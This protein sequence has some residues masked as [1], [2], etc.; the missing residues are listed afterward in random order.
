[1]RR[2]LLTLALLLLLTSSA[3]LAGSAR[4]GLPAGF[5]KQAIGSGWFE[6]VGV[7][8]DDN[9]RMYVWERVGKVWIVENG[10]KLSPPL[11][12]ISDEVGSWRDHGMLGFA[13][14]PNFLSNGW[15]YLFYAVDHYHLQNAGTPGY[16]PNV[17]ES[18]KPSIGRITRYTATAASGFKATDPASRRVLLGESAST[19]CP[20]VHDSHGVG[21][22]VFGSDDSL[23][24]GCGDGGSFLG[25]DVGG[26]AFGSYTVQALAEGIIAPRE[27]V[28]A[29][30]AQLV[31]S[32]AG[33]LLRIDAQTGDGLPSNPYYDP[34]DPRSARSRVFALGLRNPFRFTVRPDTG[35]HFQ[36]DG[37][38]GVIYLGNVGWRFFEE[39]DVI[40]SAA[41]NGG[42]PVYEAMTFEPGY[43]VE[44]APPNLDA[45][46]PLA[47]VNGCPQYFSF[48]DLLVQETL[49]APSFPNPCAPAQQIPASLPRHMHRRPAIAY[50]HSAIGPMYV[51][52]FTAG[53]PTTAEV[54]APGSPTAG[55]PIGG[56]TATGD[57][58]YTGKDFPAEFQSSYFHSDLAGFIV[59]VRFDANDKPT[60]VTPFETESTSAVVMLATDPK[61]GGLYAV[62]ILGSVF[63]ISYNVGANLPPVAVASASPG[64]GA[65][66]VGVAFTGSASTDPEGL[67]LTH[68][69]NF[70]DGSPLA[71][72]A[73]PSHT[74]FGPVGVPTTYTITLTVTD[75][76]GQPSVALTQVVVN[77][78]PPAVAITSPP[79]QGLFSMLTS[80]VYPLT[81]N[82]SDLE[83]GAGQLVCQWQMNLHHNAHAHPL[84]ETAACTSSATVTP[85]GCEGSFDYY[86]FRLTV[87]DGRG[88]ST[89]REVS[90][91]PDCAPLF[92]V[93]CGNIDANSVRNMVD[94]LRLRNAF[95]NPLTAGLST[96]E[97][98]RC[99][100][101][102]DTTCDLV[103]LTVL[104]RYLVSRAPGIYP[105]CTAA[106]P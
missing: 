43:E 106:S 37:D 98:A 101:I 32:L 55:T 83:Q 104:R 44:I 40:D 28:G 90:I 34:L 58:W 89:A 39:I 12:D 20:L 27:D 21:A 99:S 95:A 91:Y 5:T 71:T 85:I 54:G 10:V 70:G 52:T 81:A 59:N 49:A 92:P 18:L 47:G 53:A 67:P 64:F 36:A 76:L 19:G 80:T 74:F 102:G 3:W 42:W 72:Q 77:N 8:F 78:T 97:R 45:P 105:V 68:S 30:R 13:L 61:T 1:M 29:Y 63:R 6:P 60:L 31:S 7:A 26:P 69:W 25:A 93:I 23:L 2:R 65:T 57:V 103:D 14:H 22:L 66:P 51:P 48:R 87:D 41:Y 11:I 100:V 46:N 73:N 75:S 86:S 56:F 16:D 4:A 82:V 50:G 96:G 9:G 84:A 33:K 88:L 79:N 15:F 35:S 17:S 62:D 38:P 94:V 24:A